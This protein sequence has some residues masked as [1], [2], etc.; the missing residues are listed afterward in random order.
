MRARRAIL[1]VGPEIDAGPGARPLPRRRG[2]TSS[3]LEGGFIAGQE[4]ALVNQ[5]DGRPAVPRD[6]L[7]PGHRVAASTAGRRWSPTPRRS[8]SWR[9]VARYGADWFRSAGTADD[10]GTSLFTISGA[11]GPARR[12]RGRRAAAAARGPRSRPD[13][14]RPGGG[15]GRR[16][17]RRLGARRPT[18]DVRLTRADL[19]PYGAA[20]GAGVL[21]VLDVDTCP[22]DFAAAS[23]LPRRRVGRA[24]A[25]RASTACRGW[26]R[27]AAAGR[28]RPRPAAAGRDRA[29]GALVT[30]RGACAHPDGTARFVGSTLDVFHGHVA[31]HLEGWC[32][33]RARRALA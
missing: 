17:P 33:S 15:A 16:L 18:L 30:G 26:R 21:H 19:A 25:A 23:R 4:T 29:D 10:P 5:L 13:R 28:R 11:V 22:L 9:C 1:A 32:P 31:A 3:P 12:G 20:V 24:S 7:H 8:P 27:P 2:S 6:P 14:P